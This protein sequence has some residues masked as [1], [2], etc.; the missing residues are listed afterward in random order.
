[1][2]TI[3]FHGDSLTEASDIDKNYSWPTLIEN[4]LNVRI[5]N[6]GIGGDTSGGLLARFY[7][8]VV[9]HGPDMVVILGGTNDLWWDLEVNLIQANIFAMTCQAEF[10]K[11]TPIVGLPLPLLTANLQRQEMMA[12]IAGWPKCVQKLADL[13]AALTASAQESDIAL[14]DFYHPFIGQ[15]GEPISE[16]YLEDGLHPNKQGHL[17][18]AEKAVELLC[19]QFY[20]NIK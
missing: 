5:I 20:F 7:P 12:P 4:R 3:V 8:D 9:Q 11:I 2:K 6:S 10:H 13:A 1:M 14:L 16:Y 17:L 18:M 15:N 19:R